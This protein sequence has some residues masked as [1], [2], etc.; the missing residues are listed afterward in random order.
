MN[1]ESRSEPSSPARNEHGHF[2]NMSNEGIGYQHGYQPQ[3]RDYKPT[4]AESSS[5]PT[6]RSEPWVNVL[7]TLE[8]PVTDSLKGDDRGERYRLLMAHA[9]EQRRRIEAWAEEQ[10]LCDEIVRFGEPN[11]FQLLFVYC[12]PHAARQLVRAPGVIDVAI[13]QAA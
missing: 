7:L 2:A 8:R 3:S 9:R 5:R 10:G 4:A 13:A 11:S 12:T 6:R 1:V